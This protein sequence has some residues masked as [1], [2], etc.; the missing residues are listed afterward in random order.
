MV[1]R[2]RISSER[3][4]RLRQM[5]ERR[6]N[7]CMKRRKLM[8]ARVEKLII[9][10]Q[11]MMQRGEIA[12]QKAAVALTGIAKGTPDK[13][14]INEAEILARQ[15]LE[16]LKHIEIQKDKLLRTVGKLNEIAGRVENLRVKMPELGFLEK[17]AA[18]KT[19]KLNDFLNQ[20]SEW[21]KKNPM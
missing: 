9:E 1:K 20:L 18:E 4:L 7:S 3:E 5:A 21:K 13:K 10:S 8:Q 15:Y 12:P 16:D 19:E 11:K 6:T 17:G 2:K 14:A